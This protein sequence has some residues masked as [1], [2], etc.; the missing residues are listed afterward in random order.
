MTNALYL[1]IYMD[2]S[3]AHLMEFSTDEIH[4]KIIPSA[5]S[6][7]DD[8]FKGERHTHYKE[9]HELAAFY[10]ELGEIMLNYEEVL[11]FGPTEAKEELFNL[12]KTAPRFEKL[13]IT[14]KTSDKINENQKHAFVRDYFS[15][16][17]HHLS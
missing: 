8:D 2:H 14:I 11:L 3:T 10:K 6:P 7:E 4:T 16:Q 1:G 13:K 9:Q 5:F 15:K 12:L 17:I